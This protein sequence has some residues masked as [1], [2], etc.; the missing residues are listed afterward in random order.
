[1]KNFFISAFLL[2][3]FSLTTFS[4]QY[5]SALPIEAKENVNVVAENKPAVLLEL[6]TSE[7][8]PTCPPAD[9]LLDLLDKEQPNE[10]AEIITLAL[11]V[12]YWDREDWRDKYSSAVFSRRQDIYS[13]AF[14]IGE[15]YTPM[16]IVDGKDFFGGAKA[17][18]VHKAINKSAR[19]K[20]AEIEFS[21]E[22]DKVKVEIAKIPEHTRSTVYL[23]IAED[24]L[25]AGVRR[26]KDFKHNSVVRK[27]RS[28]GM[29]LPEK[30]SFIAETFIQ[31][32]ED[33]KKDNLKFVVFIQEN[34]SRKGLG[35]KQIKLNASSK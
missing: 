27:L 22:K 35:V 12:D 8:C 16:M 1:M 20:K 31:F 4:F 10:N 14:K 21:V 9:M 6:F 23:A 5:N 33:W 34:R 7:G 29:L 15:V 3:I 17:D 28:L 25:E 24:N 19:E 30:N 13:Q 26:S 2:L 32:E 18:K 11:H